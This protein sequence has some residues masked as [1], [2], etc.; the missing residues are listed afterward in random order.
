MSFR[1]G[2]EKHP[3]RGDEG[4]TS[5]FMFIVRNVEFD[6]ICEIAGSRYLWENMSAKGT[7]VEQEED[8]KGFDR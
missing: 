7:N 5:E 1:F 6:S 4:D 3:I 8:C 2:S